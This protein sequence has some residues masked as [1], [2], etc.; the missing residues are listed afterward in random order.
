MWWWLQSWWHLSLVTWLGFESWWLT[1]LVNNLHP[2]T[3]HL[4]SIVPRIL[5]NLDRTLPEM[6]WCDRKFAVIFRSPFVT[7]QFFWWET[8]LSK[9]T[10]CCC[11]WKRKSVCLILYAYWTVAADRNLSANNHEFFE[12]FFLF[13]CFFFGMHLKDSKRSLTVK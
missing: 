8:F 4:L 12:V 11:V 6:S 5:L 3:P 1:L 9:G 13:P 2:N 10:K 7:K